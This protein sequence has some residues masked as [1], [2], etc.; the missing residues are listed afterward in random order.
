MALELTAVYAC[1]LA[2]IQGSESRVAVG[3]VAGLQIVAKAG[4]PVVHSE[5]RFLLV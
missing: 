2:G 3:C 4:G 5:L 1:C